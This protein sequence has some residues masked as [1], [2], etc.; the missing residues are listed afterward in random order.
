MASGL[1]ST[2]PTAERLPVRMRGDLRIQPRRARGRRYWIVKDPVALQYFQLRDEEHFL[3]RQLDG[4]ASLDDVQ[5]A[6]A[7]EFAPRRLSGGSCRRS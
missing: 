3:L 6:F 2:R 1:S 7:R 4:R 5:S